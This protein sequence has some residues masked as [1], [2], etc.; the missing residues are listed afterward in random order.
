M[1]HRP[2][3]CQEQMD[4]QQEVHYTIQL[5]TIAT[6]GATGIGVSSGIHPSTT[7]ATGI[8]ND[9]VAGGAYPH[10][11]GTFNAIIPLQ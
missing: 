9:G 2:T 10:A 1:Y 4:Y 7:G 3:V 8:S 11:S 6:T 5:I